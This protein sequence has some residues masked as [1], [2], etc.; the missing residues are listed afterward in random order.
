[1]FSATDSHTH[2]DAINAYQIIPADPA[3]D[4]FIIPGTGYTPGTQ[5]AKAG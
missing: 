5:S 3:A 1:L 4:G 2:A